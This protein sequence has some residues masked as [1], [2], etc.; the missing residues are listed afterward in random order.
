MGRALWS[1]VLHLHKR[2]G[3]MSANK[4][5]NFL[6]RSNIVEVTQDSRNI[7]DW[8][9]MRCRLFNLHDQAPCS[10]RFTI[11]DD[12]QFNHSIYIDLFF[13]MK[14]PILHVIDE[15]TRFQSA[16]LLT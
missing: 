14:C 2:F 3:H 6:E 15:S 8:I 7:L 12:L 10:P 9:S 16:R 4:L 13:I 1:E 11:R 5:A